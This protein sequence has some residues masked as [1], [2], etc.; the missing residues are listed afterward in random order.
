MPLNFDSNTTEYLAYVE[1]QLT[2]ATY[3]FGT[4][5]ATLTDGTAID[6]LVTG[7]TRLRRSVGSLIDPRLLFPSLSISLDNKPEQDGSRTQDLLHTYEWANKPA[8]IYVG[9]GTDATSYELI[10]SGFVKFPGGIAWDEEQV[11][12]LL[13]DARAKDGRFLPTGTFTTATYANME[14]LKANTPIP[15]AYGSWLSTDEGALRVP[16]T[17]IDSTAGTGGKFKIAGHAIKQIESVF[18]NGVSVSFSSPNLATAEFVLDV[19][20]DAAAGD[21]ISVHMRGATDDGTASG[22][23]LVNAADIF[24]DMLKTLMSVSSS[25][26][27]ST[28]ISNWNAELTAHDQMRR[29]IGVETHSD[30]LIAELLSEGFADLGVENGKYYPRYRIVTIGASLPQ[31]MEQDI[32]QLGDNQGLRISVESAPEEIYA[33]EILG[34]YQYDPVGLTYKGRELQEDSSAITDKGQRVRRILSLNYLYKAQGAKDRVSR[35]LFVFGGEPEMVTLELNE[36]A[37]VLEPSEQFRLVANK[38]SETAELGVPF[39]VRDINTD[40]NTMTASVTAWNILRLATGTWT[41][42]ISVTWLTASAEQRATKGFWTDANGFADT[43]GSPDANSKAYR[44]L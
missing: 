31:F 36:R 37:V 12:V 6:G 4:R 33:N 34:N 29:W 30:D 10:Y 28:A 41:E 27:D 7:M 11:E 3:R 13:Q 43:S 2:G 1:F 42:D 17:Q 15:I 39:Q 22:D 21:V 18:K 19:A 8:L 44:Y 25:S 38:Y 35:E 32:Q 20:Y 26:I 9:Q 16:A 5:Y 23:L 40:V 24:N 14:A